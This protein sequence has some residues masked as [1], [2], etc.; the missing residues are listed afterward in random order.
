MG[1][2]KLFI[3]TTLEAANFFSHEKSFNTP[4]RPSTSLFF[5]LTIQQQTGALISLPGTE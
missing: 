1:K 2:R 4:S 3:Q 5:F